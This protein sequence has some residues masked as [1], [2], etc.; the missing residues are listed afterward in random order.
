MLDLVLQTLPNLK[1]GVVE[2]R[3]SHSTKDI[4]DPKEISDALSEIEKLQKNINESKMSPN[5]KP[6]F[7]LGLSF[8]KKRPSIYN[9]QNKEVKIGRKRPRPKG[10]MIRKRSFNKHIEEPIAKRSKFNEEIDTL[11]ALLNGLELDTTIF[12]NKLEREDKQSQ[13][14]LINTML[15]KLKM[16]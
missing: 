14:N 2:Y 3:Q 9:K 16:S 12:R 6:T 7:D 15:N 4:D 1:E 8:K 5:D 10:N 13:I 11:L